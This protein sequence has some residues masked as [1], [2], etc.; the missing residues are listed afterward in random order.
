MAYQYTATNIDAWS[1]DWKCRYISK[2]NRQTSKLERIEVK[3]DCLVEHSTLLFSLHV[4]CPIDWLFAASS[5]TAHSAHWLNDRTCSIQTWMR[6]GIYWFRIC[7]TRVLWQTGLR[8]RPRCGNFCAATRHA[9][10]SQ[11]LHR[12]YTCGIVS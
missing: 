10:W 3:V 7:C 6:Y 5:N 1:F 9:R 4:R 8:T 12:W 11:I 2:C